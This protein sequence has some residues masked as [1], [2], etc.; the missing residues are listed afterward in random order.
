VLGEYPFH[1][2]RVDVLPTRDD[3]VF[4]SVSDL[5]VAVSVQPA[6]VPG[7]Q[8]AA[9]HR[10]GRGL[11]PGPVT[12]A[13]RPDGSS[14]S[15]ALDKLYDT[16]ASWMLNTASTSALLGIASI[17]ARMLPAATSNPGSAIKRSA[18]AATASAE[19]SSGVNPRAVPTP[20]QRA[21][22]MNWSAP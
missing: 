17:S 4:D 11:R 3:H 13:P 18:D 14:N 10:P 8:P 5:Q 12:P 6:G 22:F 2:G 21:V 20:V 1:H 15:R 19:N 16:A 9:A 7:V